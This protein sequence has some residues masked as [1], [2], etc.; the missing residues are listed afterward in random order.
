MKTIYLLIALHLVNQSLSAPDCAAASYC[1][2]CVYSACFSCFNNA[3]TQKSGLSSYA[4]TCTETMPN[5]YQINHCQRYSSYSPTLVYTGMADSTSFPKCIYCTDDYK[6]LTYDETTGI[7]LCTSYLDET[8]H[9][10]QPKEVHCG[11]ILGCRQAVCY[12]G[13]LHDWVWCNQCDYGYYPD[14]IEQMDSSTQ[15]RAKSCKE[16]I[17]IANCFYY[18]HVE[19]ST[20]LVCGSCEYG[21]VQTFDGSACRPNEKV[22]TTQN[23][24]RLLNDHTEDNCYECWQGYYFSGAYCVLGKGL[25]MK[26]GV[27]GIALLTL[28]QLFI[29]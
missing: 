24:N 21:Y 10:L 7:E 11:T 17:K 19:T 22:T 6:Y 23:C 12:H 3:T 2:A 28:I 5:A 18:T 13:Q 25:L 27:L 29:C 1:S 9:D 8:F 15:Y 26:V 14:A 16:G 20:A 4:D